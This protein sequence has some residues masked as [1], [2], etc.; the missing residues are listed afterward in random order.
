MMI[1]VYILAV[2]W[3]LG[4]CICLLTA[5]LLAFVNAKKGKVAVTPEDKARAV[6]P[7]VEGPIAAAMIGV[8]VIAFCGTVMPGLITFLVL[9][10]TPVISA[11]TGRLYHQK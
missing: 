3:A 8:V 11:L 2:M 9:A 4:G 1:I 5:N 10:I 6:K 7:F